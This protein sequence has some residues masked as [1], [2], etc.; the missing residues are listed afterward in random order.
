MY[1]CTTF[2]PQ[3]TQIYQ[4]A[5]LQHDEIYIIARYS[6]FSSSHVFLLMQITITFIT[7]MHL[8]LATPHCT[9]LQKNIF[10]RNSQRQKYLF[11]FEKTDKLHTFKISITI[12]VIS[13]VL[14]IG[15]AVLFSSLF[16]LKQKTLAD[17]WCLVFGL[18]FTR[19]LES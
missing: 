17:I 4:E 12:K 2:D 15:L 8:K 6:P 1:L 18:N 11:H 13:Y 9:A 14:F 5:E 10:L 19:T 16:E 3:N 7:L